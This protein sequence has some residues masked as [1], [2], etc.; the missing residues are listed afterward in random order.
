VFAACVVLALATL[1]WVVVSVAVTLHR[2][3][4]D[5]RLRDRRTEEWLDEQTRRYDLQAAA[6][7]RAAQAMIAA[8][9]R[10]PRRRRRDT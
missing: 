1:G 8:R 7:E 2:D 3:G 5:S 9:H 4:R 6:H 10:A